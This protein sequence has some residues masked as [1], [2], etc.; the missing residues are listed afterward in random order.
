MA[1]TVD[2]GVL[3]GVDV[4]VTVSEGVK[5]IEAVVEAVAVT[6]EV[7]DTDCVAVINWLGVLSWV[8]DPVAPC[9]LVPV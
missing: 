4:M 9:E 3:E 8:A 6:E 1:D 5:V 7:P 2:E